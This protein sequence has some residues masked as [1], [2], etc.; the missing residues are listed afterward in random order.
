MTHQ[1]L[2]RFI[3]SFDSPEAALGYAVAEA[4]AWIGERGSPLPATYTE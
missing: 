1:C 4:V 2:M 3:P